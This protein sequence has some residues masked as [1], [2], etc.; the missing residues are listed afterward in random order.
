[1][2]TWRASSPVTIVGQT[3]IK[4]GYTDLEILFQILFNSF[5]VFC[6]FLSSVYAVSGVSQHGLQTADGYRNLPVK[7]VIRVVGILEAA[8]EHRI[9]IVVKTEKS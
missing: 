1:M 5:A 9:Q 2:Q 3:K 6:V 7:N 8:R 4:D